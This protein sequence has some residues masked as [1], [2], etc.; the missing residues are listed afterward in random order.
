MQSLRDP[1]TGCPW[2]IEQTYRTIAPY[3]IE[4]AYEVADAIERDDMADLRGELGDLLL[5]VVYHA[6]IGKEGGNFDFAEIAETV[7]DKMVK[8][9]PHVFGSE[10]R[11]KSAAQQTRDWEDIKE[12]ERRSEARHGGGTLSNVPVGLAALTRSAKLQSR[13]A[14]VGF[15]WPEIGSVAGKVAEEAAE[16]SEALA[17]GSPDHRVAEEFGD[18]LFSLVGLS[19]HLGVDPEAALR[20]ANA[21]FIRRFSKVEARL[22]ERGISPDEASLSEMDALW[23]EIKAEDRNL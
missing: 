15:D 16:L 18:L 8:R 4:E 14:R 20:S 1:D 17:D 10:D 11:N 13:A 9:H 19:R 12:R 22:A 21:K 23:E 6:Q 3:T 7:S 5:Q 2:D